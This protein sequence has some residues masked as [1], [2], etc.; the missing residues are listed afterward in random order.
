MSQTSPDAYLTTSAAVRSL[1]LTS[2]P[3]SAV[4]QR[5]TGGEQ[6]WRER[7]VRGAPAVGHAV[8]ERSRSHPGSALN[9]ISALNFP[10]EKLS[11]FSHPLTT[12]VLSCPVWSSDL[13]VEESVLG[14]FISKFSLIT[15]AVL[16]SKKMKV[17][18]RFS[19]EEKILPGLQKPCA[20]SAA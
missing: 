16:L 19:R 5:P 15:Y 10:S 17:Q 4:P 1:H 14:I 13:T 20:E 3:S 2:P 9:E 12:G 18:K 6:E 8:W 11:W 7:E